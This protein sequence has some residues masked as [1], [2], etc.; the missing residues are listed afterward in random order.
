MRFDV[1]IWSRM[2]SLLRNLFYKRRVEGQLEDEVRGYVDLLTDEKVA[3]GKPLAEARREALMELG[4]VTQVK[5]AVREG[6]VGMGVE[7]LGQDVRYGWRMLRRSPGFTVAAVIS[8]GLGIG[9]TT[10]IF[11]AVYSLLL[12]PLDY[13]D[14]NALVWVSNLWPKFHM[15]TVF[16]PDFVAARTQVR[17]FEQLA[18]FTIRD[19]N[20]TDA[21]E[22]LRMSCA[23][24]TAN[25][26]SILGVAPQ[27]GRSF[28]A[29]EDRPGGAGVVLLSDRM[30]RNKF[31]A[32]P[33]ILGASITLNGEKHLVIG[34]LPAHL[35]FPDVQV[36]PDV[37]GALGVDSVTSISIEKPMMN[38]NVIGR[39][40]PGV[41]AD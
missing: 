10:A 36:E 38:L 7:T 19:E 22:P 8:L 23:Y 34:V 6:R 18:A 3:A 32:D 20:L 26:F 13:R 15:D 11:S 16:S 39:L 30:W 31:A 33:R 17:S 29:E 35:R 41:S 2:L 4:G 14:A 40:R 28:S 37:Y 12:R 27:M 24:V 25:F 5:Q 1:E 21:G 9:A